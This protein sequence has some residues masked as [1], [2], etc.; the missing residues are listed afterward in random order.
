[1]TT[2]LVGILTAH[3]APVM[4]QLRKEWNEHWWGGKPLA[5]ADAPA[6]F[7]SVNRDRTDQRLTLVCVE[8][9]RVLAACVN[10]DA[11][12]AATRLLGDKC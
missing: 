10:Y 4:N 7:K 2:N 9:G 1:M 8:T 11:L 5:W 3:T 12:C 6:V